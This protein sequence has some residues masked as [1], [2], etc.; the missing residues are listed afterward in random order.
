MVKPGAGLFPLLLIDMESQLAGQ[1][2]FLGSKDGT[3]HVEE[4]SE[5]DGYL[6]LEHIMIMAQARMYTAQLGKWHR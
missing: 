2:P 3:I 4:H 1:L 6:Q 5:L